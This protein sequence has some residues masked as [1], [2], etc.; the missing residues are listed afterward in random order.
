MA[1]Y[2]VLPYVGGATLGEL[3]R[4]RG[5]RQ[6]DAV[7]DEGRRT[8]EMGGIAGRTLGGIF[9]DYAERQRDAPRREL[10]A[11]QLAEAQDRIQRDRQIREVGRLTQGNP[12]AYAREVGLI[13]PERGRT[14]AADA[15]RQREQ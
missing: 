10:E 14:L 15:T 3:A 7:L 11:L 2:Q 4:R 13:D 12:D 9:S 6:A 1:G 8:A 5:Y